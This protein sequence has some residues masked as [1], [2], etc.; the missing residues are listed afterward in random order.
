MPTAGDRGPR[1]VLACLLSSTSHGVHPLASKFEL[2]AQELACVAVFARSIMQG[3]P[4]AAHRI[5][6]RFRSAMRRCRTDGAAP[7]HRR[8]NRRAHVRVSLALR[9]LDVLAPPAALADVIGQAVWGLGIRDL[10]RAMTSSAKSCPPVVGATGIDNCCPSA[11]YGQRCIGA[12]APRQRRAA[13]DNPCVALQKL[14]AKDDELLYTVASSC[15]GPLF[16]VASSRARWLRRHCPRSAAGPACT[17]G[18]EEVKGKLGQDASARDR[19]QIRVRTRGFC[20]RK[21]AC[22]LVKKFPDAIRAHSPVE[23]RNW[24]VSDNIRSTLAQMF[25]HPSDECNS[26][27]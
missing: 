10:R 26:V 2:R 17:A 8:Q 16:S 5:A 4:A 14:V 18:V 13:N 12:L 19:N 25:T 11:R 21:S 24:A 20:L 27:R 7:D 3:G 22:A 23:A 1:A 15:V 6:E 9:V